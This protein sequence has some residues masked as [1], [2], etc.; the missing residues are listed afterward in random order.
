MEKEQL[1]CSVRWCGLLSGQ[2]GKESD[3]GVSSMAYVDDSVMLS[4]TRVDP[5]AVKPL[6]NYHFLSPNIPAEGSPERTKPSGRNLTEMPSPMN[7]CREAR[8]AGYKEGLLELA[9]WLGVEY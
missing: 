7:Y 5:E 2:Y 3:G 9:Q 8:K 6:C 4:N 1:H